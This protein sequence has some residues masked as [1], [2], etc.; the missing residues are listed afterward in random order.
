M[1]FLPAIFFLYTTHPSKQTRL[2]PAFIIVVPNRSWDK[3]YRMTEI[4]RS[5]YS[6][7][8][9]FRYFHTVLITFLICHCGSTA[10]R[11]ADSDPQEVHFLLLN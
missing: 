8:G 4:R 6:V 1:V 10:E 3:Y 7:T 2:I 11:A 9:I 5:S